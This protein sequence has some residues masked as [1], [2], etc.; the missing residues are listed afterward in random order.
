MRNSCKGKHIRDSQPSSSGDGQQLSAELATGA[1]E[2]FA[3]LLAALLEAR[4]SSNWR[5]LCCLA[6]VKPALRRK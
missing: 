6:S 5:K 2:M 3:L 1:E 4:L